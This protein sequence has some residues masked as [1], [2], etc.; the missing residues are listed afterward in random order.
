M[1]RGRPHARSLARLVRNDMHERP[2]HDL[3]RIDEDRSVARHLH[4]AWGAAT[5]IRVISA[6]DMSCKERAPYAQDNQ[7]VPDLRERGGGAAFLGEPRLRDCV[8]WSRA[9]RV[10]L[11]SLRPSTTSISLRLPVSLLERIK[12][13]AHK[14][15]VPYKSL[16]K[17]WL[18]EKLNAS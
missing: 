16:I 18:A 15:D 11:P 17:T 13:A 8:D 6:C 7:A 10:R 2:F 4:S 12:L 14:R 3:G 5:R 1:R 9:E